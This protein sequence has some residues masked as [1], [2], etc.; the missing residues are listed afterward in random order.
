MHSDKLVNEDVSTAAVVEHV[1]MR[2]ETNV[3][4]D[5]HTTD[6]FSVNDNVIAREK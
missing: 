4:K 3:K 6:I 1:D 5:Q 2:I